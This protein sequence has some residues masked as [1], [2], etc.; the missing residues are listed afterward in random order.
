M[1]AHCVLDGWLAI[2]TSTAFF[3]IV[4]WPICLSVA[5][6]CAHPS[7]SPARSVHLYFAVAKFSDLNFTW[8]RRNVRN[9]FAKIAKGFES[10]RT[11]IFDCDWL[12][13][14]VHAKVLFFL[15]ALHKHAFIWLSMNYENGKPIHTHTRLFTW[16]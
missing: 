7:I 11:W 15:L 8:Q 4:W 3:F 1:F 13:Q 10:I 16:K 2:N 6:F 12:M 9:L 5:F 14:L